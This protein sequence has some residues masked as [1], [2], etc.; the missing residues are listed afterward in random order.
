MADLEPSFLSR[1]EDPSSEDFDDTM[2]MK[3]LISK[4][5]GDIDSLFREETDSKTPENICADLSRDELYRRLDLLA[6]HMLHM[7]EN[8]AAK[9]REMDTGVQQ[10]WLGLSQARYSMGNKNVSPLQYPHK[11]APLVHVCCSK[12]P[13]GLASLELLE[14]G[15]RMNRMHQGPVETSTAEG[16]GVR[17]RKNQTEMDT[18]G[19]GDREHTS[20][21]ESRDKTSDEAQDKVLPQDPLKW[22]GVLVPQSLR[23]AQQSFKQAI[24]ISVELASLQVQL[25][26]AQEL[27][28]HLLKKK[29]QLLL[30]KTRGCDVHSSD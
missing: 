2:G 15:S 8:M 22:F 7:L 14:A 13:A 12:M 19:S 6:W 21:L 10:G 30:S 24:P 9:R 26:D 23:Q 25:H 20:S 1:K 11:M 27:Y 4:K 18:V 28:S 29:Q 16:Q 17:R 5:L 3:E